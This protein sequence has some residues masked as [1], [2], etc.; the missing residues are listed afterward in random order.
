[1]DAIAFMERIRSFRNFSVYRKK[2]DGEVKLWDN[3]KKI[4]LDFIQ[5]QDLMIIGFTVGKS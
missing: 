1:M 2:T 3:N 4:E 5:Q